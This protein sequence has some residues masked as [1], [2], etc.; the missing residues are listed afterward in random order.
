ML[1]KYSELKIAGNV[2]G[3][4]MKQFAEENDTSVQVIRDVAFGYTK[5]QRLQAAIDKKIAQANQVWEEHRAS[6]EPDHTF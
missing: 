3:F 1:D 2:L 4:T 6:R 5:S